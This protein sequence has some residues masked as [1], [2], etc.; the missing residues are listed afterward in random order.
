MVIAAAIRF[1]VLFYKCSFS[2]TW[3]MSDIIPITLGLTSIYQNFYFSVCMCLL[4]GE[5]SPYHPGLVLK[6]ITKHCLGSLVTF[7]SQA[8]PAVSPTPQT[9][10]FS[11][12]YL[13]YYRIRP[14]WSKRGYVKVCMCNCAWTH[15][16]CPFEIWCWSRKWAEP[17]P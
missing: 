3:F 16:S 1:C 11:H 8:H 15:A 17:S 14:A 2:C 9:T 4:F 12:S 5:P 10:F 7:I 13:P 6:L